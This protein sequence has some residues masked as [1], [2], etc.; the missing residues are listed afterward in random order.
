MSSRLEEIGAR[1]ELISEQADRV[2]P[3]LKE[4]FET[5]IAILDRH[6]IAPGDRDG[7]K[8]PGFRTLRRVRKDLGENNA[9]TEKRLSTFLT[10]AQLD[11][12]EVLQAE[13]R[14]KLRAQLF[15]R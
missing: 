3:V 6:G 15:Q 7:D 2:R 10:E 8:R 12:Y 14:K 9:R 4:H 11:A 1:L 5:Q 13:Q